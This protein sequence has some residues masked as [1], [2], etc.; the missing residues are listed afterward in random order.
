MQGPASPRAELSA[1]IF[2]CSIGAERGL[3]KFAKGPDRQRYCWSPELQLAGLANS[4][5]GPAI[6]LE[7]TALVHQPVPAF[8]L[9]DHLQHLTEV[10]AP[11]DLAS[12]DRLERTAVFRAVQ[13]FEV[14]PL[15]FPQRR[16]GIQRIDE[17]APRAVADVA[18]LLEPVLWSLQCA[19]AS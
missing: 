4:A 19:K 14:E 13:R 2:A 7:P 1:I 5:S 3:A 8:V 15:T 9:A 12:G 16:A 6:A 17:Q 18:P 10:I 11:S